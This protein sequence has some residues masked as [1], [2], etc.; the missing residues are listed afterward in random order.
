MQMEGNNDGKFCVCRKNF[1]YIDLI[2]SDV[3]FGGYFDLKT[4]HKRAAW[5]AVSNPLMTGKKYAV[6]R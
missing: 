3:E 1:E 4:A 2:V 5:R 6:Q